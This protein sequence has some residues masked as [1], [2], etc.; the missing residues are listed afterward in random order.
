MGGL[1]GER[2]SQF[3]DDSDGFEARQ[4]SLPCADLELIAK[5]REKILSFAVCP[6]MS[7][8]VQNLPQGAIK[9]MTTDYESFLHVTEDGRIWWLRQDAIRLG[10]GFL[11]VCDDNLQLEPQLQAPNQ[12]ALVNEKTLIGA[13][14]DAR[15]TI[16]KPT[17][18]ERDGFRYVD[19]AEFLEWLSQ[20]ICLKQSKI[21]FPD[22]LG[23]RVQIALAK[24]AAERPPQEPQAFESLTLALEDWFDKNLDELPD[25]LRQRVENEFFP[26]SWDMLTNDEERQ[27]ALMTAEDQRKVALAAAKSRRS[28]T[29]Q[30]DYKNDPATEQDRQFWW[31]FFL[32]QDDIKKQVAQ[33]E[34][35]VTPTAGEID[36]KESRLTQL[37][38]ELDR[39]DKQQ[40]VARGDYYPQRKQ[41]GSVDEAA[42]T[43]V[44][45]L[46]YPKALAILSDQL[47]A[48]WEELA[49]WIFMG[50]DDGGI[51]AY[52][53][54]NELD[55][56]P[57]FHYGIGSSNDFDCQAPLMGCWFRA[58][59][60]A[61][62]VP[63]NRY[64]TGAVLIERWRKQPGIQPEPFIRAKIA[65]SRLSDIH[66]IYG[67][68][69]GTFPDESSY[70][71]PI[72]W[73]VCAGRD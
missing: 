71:P 15:L 60:I 69:Q 72:H 30:R 36:L 59:D 70:P 63:A 19:A 56:P 53:N 42:P 67:G 5:A 13:L 73:V 9:A 2:H 4:V 22:A 10:A 49:A 37:R 21:E 8:S 34:A 35:A 24:A 58:D 47:G 52:R 43:K 27:L 3:D 64:I 32:H 48:T 65:E 14:G 41:S 23:N 62:F 28:V 7:G 16:P 26:M 6:V 45:Y 55:P 11:P 57:R 17:A 31:D 44:E 25:A 66:P 50:P 68:T 54:A 12:R 20:Y 61:T 33:W 39:M 29:L 51:S 1:Y 18:F 46:A 40:R 38:H